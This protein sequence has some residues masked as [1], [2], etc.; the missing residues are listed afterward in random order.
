VIWNGRTQ[1]SSDPPGSNHT[2]SCSS[3][4]W[5]LVLQALPSSLPLMEWEEACY[6]MI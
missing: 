4:R 2:M 5:A 6:H 1:G 3:Q